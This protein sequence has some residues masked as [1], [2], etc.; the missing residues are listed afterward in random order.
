MHNKYVPLTYFFEH[1]CSGSNSQKNVLS[2]YLLKQK[3]IE[4]SSLINVDKVFVKNKL[5]IVFVCFCTR[6]HSTPCVLKWAY[7]FR[8][9]T[10]DTIANAARLFMTSSYEIEHLI[11]AKYDVS[12]SK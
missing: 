12:T 3:K 4:F 6:L 8:F 1:N 5:Y 11:I 2:S 7:I 10:L 9:Y